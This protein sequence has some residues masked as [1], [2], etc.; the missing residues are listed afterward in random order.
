MLSA[1]LHEVA[2]ELGRALHQAPAI[3]AMRAATSAFEA[4]PAAQRILADLRAH[5]LTLARLQQS[6]LQPS[7]EQISA[8]RVCQAAVGA[9]P[10]VMTHLRA[11]S[12]VKAYLPTVAA[13]ISESLGADYGTF[14]APTSC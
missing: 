2:L 4:D 13:R 9:N 14:I 12:D 5:Q 1:A 3:S 8:L 10:T 6:G 7:E 11:S